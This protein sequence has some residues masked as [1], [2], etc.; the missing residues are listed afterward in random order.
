MTGPGF[1]RSGGAVVLDARRAADVTDLHPEALRPED[2]HPVGGPPRPEHVWYVSYGSNLL[3]ERFEVYLLGGRVAGLDREYPGGPGTAPAT[4]DRAVV[5]PGRLRFALQAPSW[6]GGGVAFWDPAGSGPGVLARAWRVRREQFLEVVHM[7]NGGL[8][9]RAAPWPPGVLRTGEA[10]V[11]EGWYSRLLRPGLLH[12]EPLLT[13]THPRPGT[14]A[15]REPSP[16]YRAVVARGVV[17][18]FGTTPRGGMTPSDAETYLLD[19]LTG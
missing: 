2:L 11:G 16:A 17:E 1:P 10:R 6:G 9:R 5:L 15:T 8:D 12:G 19:A 13:F 14:L 18:T 3:R 4:G 7:E